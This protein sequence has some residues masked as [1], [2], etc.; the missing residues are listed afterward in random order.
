MDY[1]T[2]YNELK[3]NQTK[4]IK[5]LS[6]PKSSYTKRIPS[7]FLNTLPNI[8]EILNA[9]LNK[10]GKAPGKV[11]ALFGLELPTL[12]IFSNLPVKLGR[13]I[14]ARDPKLHFCCILSYFV[15]NPEELK[16]LSNWAHAKSLVIDF[17]AG[18]VMDD[19]QYLWRL[20]LAEKL[21]TVL[22][23]FNS[24]QLDLVWQTYKSLCKNQQNFRYTL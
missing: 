19:K 21:G 5:A 7:V 18:E 23:S 11:I 3:A 8:I 13:I 1:E 2:F 10:L 6:L 16:T 17:T 14:D 22:G 20:K 24:A 9:N 15:A 4:Y 12:G